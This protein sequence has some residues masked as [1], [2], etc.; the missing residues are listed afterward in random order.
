MDLGYADLADALLAGANLSASDLG[1][2]HLM[3]ADLTGG[4]L[5][6]VILAY[7]DL[8]VSD[9]SLKRNTV[10]TLVVVGQDDPEKPTADE[11]KKTMTNVRVEVIPD[12]DHFKAGGRPEFFAA[13][14]E[15]LKSHPCK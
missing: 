13:V 7:S 4:S 10:P 8:E 6:A 14:L 2:G 5:A 15:F 9:E 12:A 11:L 3:G 1:H